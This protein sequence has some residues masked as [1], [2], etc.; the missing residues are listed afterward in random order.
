MA[1]P[2][3]LRRTALLARAPSGPSAARAN[4]TARHPALVLP[5]LHLLHLRP[6]VPVLEPVVVH[7]PVHA[8]A[9]HLEERRGLRTRE[10]EDGVEGEG[11]CEEEGIEA[12]G[13]ECRTEGHEGEE[14]E[15]EK[16]GDEGEGEDERGVG[17]C[18]SEV[19]DDGQNEVVYVGTVRG[20]WSESIS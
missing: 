16:E 3:N 14:G 11:V 4:R 8:R 12:E 18:V 9:E 19:G 6:Q 20:A 5:Q 17:G 1:P 10:G 2:R 13:E 15:E 7:E